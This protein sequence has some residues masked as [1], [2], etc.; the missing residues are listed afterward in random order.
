MSIRDYEYIKNNAQ[1]LYDNSQ[2]Y[3]AKVHAEENEGNK[4]QEKIEGLDN[5]FHELRKINKQLKSQVESLI[6]QSDISTPN[7]IDIEKI[8]YFSKNIFHSSQLFSIRLNTYDF[9]LN[10]EIPLREEKTKMCVHRKFTK[11][12]YHLREYAYNKNIRINISGESYGFINGNDVFE[13]LPYLLLDNAL[14]YSMPNKNIEVNFDEIGSQL[15]VTIKSFSIRPDNHEINNLKVRGYRG[16]N[17]E[18]VQG[19]GIGLYLAD[20]IC[21]LH[22]IDLTFKIGDNKYYDHTNNDIAYSD[23]YAI[24]KFNDFERG[25]EEDYQEEIY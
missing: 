20:A 23:F 14:K 2:G 7:E 11:I 9:T 24:L 18:G 3:I 10:P 19:Q 17:T 13:L 5:T 8:N 12:S 4:Y 6:F 25:S 1:K 22:N 15:S 21:H 16:R